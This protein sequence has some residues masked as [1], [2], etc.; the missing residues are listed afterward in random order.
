MIERVLVITLILS[1]PITFCVIGW[2]LGVNQRLEALVDSTKA[3]EE[4]TVIGH[5]LEAVELGGETTIKSRIFT[6][7][8]RILHGQV[9]LPRASGY[10]PPKEVGGTKWTKNGW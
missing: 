3:L 1:I 8:I 7:G 2:A 5:K 6:K 4:S 10:S 9:K